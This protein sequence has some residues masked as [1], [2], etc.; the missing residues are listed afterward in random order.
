M[1]TYRKEWDCCG[2]VTETDSW[3]P[4]VCP[5]CTRPN[6]LTDKRLLDIADS[7]KSQYSHD[8]TIFDEFDAF[9]FFRAIERAH[10]IGEK[11]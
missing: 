2:D 1:S 3:E 4:E 6:P 5:F 11:K 10:G 7:F 9:G 8:G